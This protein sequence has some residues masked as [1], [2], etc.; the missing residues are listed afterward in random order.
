MGDK[1]FLLVLC[2]NVVRTSDQERATRKIEE[3]KGMVIERQNL[4][5]SGQDFTKVN[6]FCFP[7]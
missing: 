3:V 6:F 2:A 1:W 4:M 7:T 5:S